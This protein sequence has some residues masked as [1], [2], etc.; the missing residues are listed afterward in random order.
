MSPDKVRKKAVL[1]RGALQH[2]DG[3]PDPTE[4]LKGQ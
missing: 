3:E 4:S 1:G 2:G